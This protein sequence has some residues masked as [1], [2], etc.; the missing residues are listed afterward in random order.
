MTTRALTLG[1]WIAAST[2]FAERSDASGKRVYTGAVQGKSSAAATEVPDFAGCLASGAG[3]VRAVGM[4]GARVFHSAT[5]LPG[6]EV[7]IYGGVETGVVP[8]ISDSMGCH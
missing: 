7:P 1:P 2:L 5:A 6:G 8:S 4:V 3:T